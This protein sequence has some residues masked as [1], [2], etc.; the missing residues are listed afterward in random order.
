M[1]KTIRLEPIGTE[2]T[3][4]TNT[5]LL[6]GL[7]Q[8]DITILQACGGRGL[9][10]TCHVF[11]K[12]GTDGLSP[13]T[14]KEQRT[15]GLITTCNETSR[16]ACQARVVGDGIVVQLPSG[17]Y[18][19]EVDNIDDLVGRRAQA[20]ILHPITGEVLV[21]ESKLITRSMISQLNDTKIKV[22]QYLEGTEEA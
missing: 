9:C 13:I 18:I 6:S 7:L 10:A 21:E 5:Q 12:N 16:L 4:D 3:V 2:S 15:L 19:N 1:S 17:T 11:I 8:Q 22:D 20:D 14:K